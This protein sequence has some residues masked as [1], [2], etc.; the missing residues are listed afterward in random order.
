MTERLFGG[1]S[2]KFFVDCASI[3]HLMLF[4]R[5]HVEVPGQAWP[6]LAGLWVTCY[7]IGELHSTIWNMKSNLR[8]VR[9]LRCQHHPC[10]RISR[11]SVRSHEQY[12]DSPERHCVLCICT[13]SISCAACILL[14]CTALLPCTRF[15]QGTRKTRNWRLRTCLDSVL[16]GSICQH[17]RLIKAIFPIWQVSNCGKHVENEDRSK[18]VPAFRFLKEWHVL[19]YACMILGSSMA[20]RRELM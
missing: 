4:C 7:G 9:G 5:N 13:A 3:W 20:R 19:K 12:D 14:S 17:L 8:C 1:L 6:A 11:R 2:P 15:S 16:P 18:Q 10:C